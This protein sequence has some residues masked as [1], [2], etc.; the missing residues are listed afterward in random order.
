MRV[1][2]C[3]SLL[4]IF[5]TT[6]CSILEDLNFLKEKKNFVHLYPSKQ[7]SFSLSTEK[8]YPCYTPKKLII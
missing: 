6:P 8:I 3:C 5:V 7:I 1:R 4:K 2:D